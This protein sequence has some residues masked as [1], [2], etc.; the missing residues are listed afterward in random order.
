MFMLVLAMDL[1]VDMW[2]VRHTIKSKKNDLF[3]RFK[4][5]SCQYHAFLKHT[6]VAIGTY[7]RETS[8]KSD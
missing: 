3:A 1:C 8:F 4:W 2:Y 6:H 7:R 5:Q